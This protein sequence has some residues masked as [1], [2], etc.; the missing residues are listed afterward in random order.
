MNSMSAFLCC[1]FLA[2]L[3][4]RLLVGLFPL[5]TETSGGVDETLVVLEAFPVTADRC[6]LLLLLSDLG[7]LSLHLSSTS[8]RSVDFSHFE[9]T[10]KNRHSESV[11]CTL[12]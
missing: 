10:K 1:L 4:G 2:E 12:R 3:S 5:A 7:S 8:K 11:P 6:L 9:K